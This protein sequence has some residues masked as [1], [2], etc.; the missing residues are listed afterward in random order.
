MAFSPTLT[1][2]PFDT[3]L[4][5]TGATRLNAGILLMAAGLSRRYRAASGGQHK[6]SGRLPGGGTVFGQSVHHAQQ[7]GLL[8]T[9]ILRPEDTGLQALA[10]RAGVPFHCVASGGLGESIAAGVAATPTWPG[11]L[12]ALADM[13]LLAPETYLQ[14]N[15]A[16][17]HA[18]CARA[19][20]GEEA[21]HPVGFRAE[22]RTALC[23]LT[24]DQGARALLKSTPPR[25]VPV[26]D[27]GCVWDIDLPDQLPRA[28][29]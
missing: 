14:V 21:G 4:F 15:A 19:V 29:Q 20:Y 1:S 6:L 17:A 18:V 12:V 25:R 5:R 26:D 27:P 23:A 10:A 13:P 7:S 2:Y 8:V 16:L 9:V 24:G 22:M 28:A 11:W 3:T